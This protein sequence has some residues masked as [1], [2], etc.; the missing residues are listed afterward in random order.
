ML[1]GRTPDQRRP[2]W[3]DARLG[4]IDEWHVDAIRLID[5][6]QAEVSSVRR[7]DTPR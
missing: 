3:S 1:A 4:L 7:T 5:S 6:A 2:A